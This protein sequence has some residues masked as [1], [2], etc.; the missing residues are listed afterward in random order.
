MLEKNLPS[1]SV[2]CTG[3]HIG[4][5]KIINL[6]LNSYY[7]DMRKHMFQIKKKYLVYFIY[8]HVNENKLTKHVRNE[9]MV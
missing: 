5:I 6:A 9:I 1:K 3:M 8:R 4:S 2:A 7:D